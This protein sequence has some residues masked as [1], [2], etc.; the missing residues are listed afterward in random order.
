MVYFLIRK[1]YDCNRNGDQLSSFAMR[2]IYVSVAVKIGFSDG[3][4]VLSPSVQK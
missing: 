2:C 3:K 1:G 4:A